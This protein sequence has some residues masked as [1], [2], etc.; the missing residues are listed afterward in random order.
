[1]SRNRTHCRHA[2]GRE[3]LGSIGSV[4]GKALK[5]ADHIRIAGDDPGVQERIPV[6]WILGPELMVKRIGIGEHLRIEQVIE[7]Q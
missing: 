6:H 3:L 4:R 2:Q 5:N 1:M 7:A